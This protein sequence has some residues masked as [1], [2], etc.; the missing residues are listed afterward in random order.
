MEVKPTALTRNNDR[1][2]DGRTD[3]LP[4]ITGTYMY[5]LG[6]ITKQPVSVEK[7]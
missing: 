7:I 1:Q 2:I 3:G 4:L 5:K 6:N